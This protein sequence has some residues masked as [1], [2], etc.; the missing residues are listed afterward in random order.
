MRTRY[1]QLPVGSDRNTPRLADVPLAEVAE[2]AARHPEAVNPRPYTSAI[3]EWPQR[4]HA[5][6]AGGTR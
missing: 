4:P 1:A 3:A 2:V 5:N 6:R